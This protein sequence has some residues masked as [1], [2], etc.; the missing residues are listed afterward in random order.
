MP[1]KNRRENKMNK[2]I[3][4]DSTEIQITDV[5]Q[6]GDILTVTI[7]TPDANAVIETFR[8][9][10]ATSV[11]RYYTDTDLIRGYA[12]FVKM[13]NVSFTPD[14]VIGT[15]YEVTDKATESGFAEETTDRCVVTMRKVSMLASVAGQVA[16]NTANIDYIAMETGTE[17]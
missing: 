15:N 5:T 16:Q 11:M 13:D 8:R 9:P 10:S 4:A 14:V 1:E 12:G 7:D 17:L 2:I 3:F 6:A